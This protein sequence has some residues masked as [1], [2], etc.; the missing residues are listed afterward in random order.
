VPLSISLDWGPSSDLCQVPALISKAKQA[1]TPA[2][3][4][5]DRGYDA[6]STHELIRREWG[7]ESVIRPNL[8]RSGA[9]RTGYWRPQM[10]EQYLKQAGYSKR[11]TVESFFSALKRTMGSMLSA[12]RP[13]QLLA[14]A[15]LKVLAYTLRR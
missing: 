1:A 3:L 12:R 9:I 15:A 5:A 14:E 10:T 2:K 11:W 6:E 8:R 7:V 4:Y 13:D